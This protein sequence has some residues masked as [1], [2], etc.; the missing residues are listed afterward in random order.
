MIFSHRSFDSL[1]A[2]SSIQCQ[3]LSFPYHCM[4]CQCF[5][6]STADLSWH[7]MAPHWGPIRGLVQY[8]Y[9]ALGEIFESNQTKNDDMN[10]D[11]SRELAIYA[12]ALASSS[13]APN[14]SA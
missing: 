10:V 12:Q 5:L 1:P 2:S 13:Y 4:A 9:G 7:T 14:S 3:N 6:R 8:T 11:N